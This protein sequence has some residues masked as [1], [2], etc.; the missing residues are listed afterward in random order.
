MKLSEK[1]E[2][3]EIIIEEIN[4][5]IRPLDLVVNYIL[6]KNNGEMGEKVLA[7]ELG[8]FIDSLTPDILEKMIDICAKRGLIKRDK[9]GNIYKKELK[10]GS[11]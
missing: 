8:L 7:K 4:E 9:D 5:T 2:L 3:T 11:E 6:W 1:G 10:K